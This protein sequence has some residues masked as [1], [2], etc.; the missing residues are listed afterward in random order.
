MKNNLLIS[1]YHH[2]AFWLASKKDIIDL[3]KDEPH[4]VVKLDKIVIEK[5]SLIKS[6][7]P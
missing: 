2:H 7:D 4:P 6:F 3:N 1:R 5:K